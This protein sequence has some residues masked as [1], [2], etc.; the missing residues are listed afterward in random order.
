MNNERRGNWQALA[1]GA[2]GLGAWTTGSMGKPETLKFLIAVKFV[3][4]YI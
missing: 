4:E 3:T 2:S 1:V